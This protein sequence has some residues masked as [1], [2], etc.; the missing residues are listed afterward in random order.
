MKPQSKEAEWNASLSDAELV[1]A[2]RRGDKKAFVEIVA[3]HQAMVCGIALGILGDFAA[4][5]DAGQEAFLTAWRKIH[6]LREPERL[7]AWLGQ[8]ARTAALGQLRRRKGHDALEDDLVLVDESPTP[9]EVAATEE[10]AALVMESLSKLPEL[11]RLPLILFYREGKSVKA[12]A[13]ALE[14]SEDAVKQRLARGREMLRERMSGM[15]ETVLGRTRPNAVFTMAVAVAIGALAAPAAVAGTVFAAATAGTSTATASSVSSFI[16][17]V[18]STSKTFLV[19][20][21]IVAAVC[22]PIGYQLKKEATTPKDN[23]AGTDAPAI[24][25]A[26]ATNAG[27]TFADSAL[28]A[29]WRALHEQY[30]TNAQAMPQLHKAISAMKDAFRR[31]AFRA[32][33]ISEWVEIDPAGGFKFMSGKGIDTTQRRQ[34]FEEWLAR[35]PQ[36]AVA[37]LIAGGKAWEQVARDSL[38][39]VARKAPSSLPEVASYLPKSDSYWDKSMGEAFA[40]LAEG[41]F[42]S[43]RKAAE[44]VTGPNRGPALG[45][46]AKIWAKS[47]LDGAV[48]WARSLPEGVDR[49]EIIRDALVGR[50]AVDPAGA[51]DAVSLVPQGGRHAYFASSTGAQV[52]MEAANTDFDATVSWLGAH[53][54]RMGPGDLEG[55]AQA[56]TDRLNA[57]RTGFLTTYGSESAMSALL[58]GINSALLNSA[59]GQRGAVWDWL[60]TQPDNDITMALKER[61]LS[62][63]GYQ[64]PPLAMKLVADLPATPEG[65]AE[66]TSVA[67]AIFNG[68]RALSRFDEVWAQAPDRMRQPL[69]DA[70]LNFLSGDN[71]DDAQRWIARISQFPD[72]SRSAGFAAVAGAWAQQ[73][74]ELAVAWAGSMSPGDTRTGA[75]AAIAGSWG[76]SDARGAADWVNSLPAGTE[77][78]RSVESL[79]TAAA[80]Q[81]PTEAWDWALSIGDMDARTRAAQAAATAMAARDPETARQWIEASSFDEP[82]KTRLMAALTK[83]NVSGKTQ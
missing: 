15:I 54:G 50:A 60:N 81:D 32:A 20:T 35:D 46:I 38:K 40:I 44:E 25:L 28:F 33:L 61:V 67:R 6:D 71:L 31:S 56:A 58:P 3:R 62:S 14:I 83:A 37:A 65:D 22:I 73:S 7:R 16:T 17:T 52:L 1:L 66:V 42:E 13:E 5:E 55:L 10:E 27:P 72:A 36:S 34:F 70:A 12:V 47:D 69:V 82:V 48:A 49:D 8:I 77:R 29:E 19:A 68:G 2:A 79:V 78:D 39:E 75:E 45:G 74:P 80:K 23:T 21:A 76:A 41:N 4:S 59:G 53:P 18:M 51:L 9:D 64:D 11:H 43:A 24:T 63:A 30:G 57:D 26:L